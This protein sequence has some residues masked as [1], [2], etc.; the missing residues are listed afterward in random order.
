MQQTFLKEK[1]GYI[2]QSC[3]YFILYAV[4]YNF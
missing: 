4:N 1:E 2:M 3:S